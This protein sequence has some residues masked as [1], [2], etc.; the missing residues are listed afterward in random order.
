MVPLVSPYR[1]DDLRSSSYFLLRRVVF[2]ELAR[3][4]GFIGSPEPSLR[5]ARATSK[6]SLSVSRG[7]VGA[8]EGGR[9]NFFACLCGLGRSGSNFCAVISAHL[10]DRKSTRLNS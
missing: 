4:I 2:R 6:D 7:N 10:K 8:S 9:P 1:S 3:R 5:I